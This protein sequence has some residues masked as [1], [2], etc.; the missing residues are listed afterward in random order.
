VTSPEDHDRALALEVDELG[1]VRLTW[2]AGVRITG[3]LA[4]AAVRLVD[5]TNAGRRRPL[6]VDIIGTP[7]LTR[8]ARLVFSRR[9]S[10]SRIGLLGV[11]AVHRVMANFVIQVRP[12]PV[13]MRFFTSEPTAVAW[14]CGEGRGS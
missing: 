2:T 3:G 13:P 6:L 8:E 5:E 12:A 7:G 4:H 1:F 11:S 9:C 14:L 10:A